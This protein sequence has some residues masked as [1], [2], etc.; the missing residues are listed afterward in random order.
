M[1]PFS[2]SASSSLKSFLSPKASIVPQ[3]SMAE[4]AKLQSTLL[5]PSLT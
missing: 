5:C 1:Q 2:C 4:E 3:A